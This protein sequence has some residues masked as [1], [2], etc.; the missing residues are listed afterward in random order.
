MAYLGGQQITGASWVGP[1]A[2]AVEFTASADGL[3]RQLYAGRRLIGVT[4]HPDDREVIGQL[5]QSEW[6]Q[7]LS[8][9]AVDTANRAT[10]YGDTFGVGPWNAVRVRVST[11]SYP[12]DAARLEVTAGT[13]AGGAVDDT[14]ILGQIIFEGDAT[15]EFQTQ[16]LGDT[17]TWNLEVTPYDDKG[18]AGTALA[19]SVALTSRPQDVVLQTDDTRLFDFSIAAQTLNLSV[20]LP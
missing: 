6:P 5:I 18:N 3:L 1:N 12:A 19:T 2:I 10:D 9:V 7:D 8:L 17:G 11:S 20:V 14:N 13:T 15:Y 16:P 4:L